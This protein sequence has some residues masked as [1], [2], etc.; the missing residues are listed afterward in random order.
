MTRSEHCTFLYWKRTQIYVSISNKNNLCNFLTSLF[1]QNLLSLSNWILQN[2]KSFHFKAQ[3]S[4]FRS[5]P[6]PP[7]EPYHDGALVQRLQYL[8][9]FHHTV[10]S[11][12]RHIRLLFLRP[13]QHLQGTRT[14]SRQP[15]NRLGLGMSDDNTYSPRIAELYPVTSQV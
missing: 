2:F 14:S 11:R 7:E 3:N 13:I 10:L 6:F 15:V 12:T 9:N 4:L 8:W 1:T 5:V